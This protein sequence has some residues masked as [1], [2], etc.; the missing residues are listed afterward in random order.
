MKIYWM[1][2]IFSIFIYIW[3]QNNYRIVNINGNYEKRINWKPA[4]I[5]FAVI[6]FFCG[7][8]S[9]IADT[10]TYIHMFKEYPSAVSQIDWEDVNK[11]KGFYLISVVFKHLISTDFHGW[12]FLIALI[13]G[14]ATMYALKKYSSNF[15][16]SCYLFIASTMFTYLINGMRQY[17]CVSIMFACTGLI[18]ERKFWKYIC[19]VLLLSTIHA[20]VLIFI[21]VYFIVNVRPWS[22]RMF[23]IVIASGIVAVGFDKLLPAFGNML[24]ET[25]YAGYV[26]YIANEGVGSNVLRLVI[27]A[28]PCILAFIGR[29]I[30]EERENTLINVAINMSV[31]NLCLYFIA[32][33]SS[34]MVIGRLTIY[35][36]IFNLLLLPWLLKYIFN[37][38]SGSIITMICMVFY[39]V[40][41]YFQMVVTWQLGYES[42]ILHLYL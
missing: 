21:P 37:E 16:F 3:G 4:I 2:F 17:I 10:G 14:L 41:F 23:L 38:K 29:Y 8:R 34:G 35:F 11:D 9:G 19:I 15:G 1:F 6:I 7:L 25:Q 32:T 18:I 33:F 36:D 28:I 39:A 24:E 27:A 13:S 20:S 12:L 5:F 30:I 26:T 42:D 40:Y 22:P 31:I